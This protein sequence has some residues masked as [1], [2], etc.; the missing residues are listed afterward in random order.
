MRIRPLPATLLAATLFG[1][2]SAG[3]QPFPTEAVLEP[4]TSGVTV[5]LHAVSPVDESVVWVSGQ[6]GTWVRTTDG[7]ATWQGGVV[8]GGEALEMRDVHAESATE[9]WLL[10]AGPGDASRIYH[11]TD[12]GATWRLQWTND[13]PAGFYDCME[14]WDAR[15]GAVY[16]DAVNGELRVLRTEDGGATWRLVP[17]SAL[18]RAL[19]GE[20]G[21]AASGTCLT[22]R[23]GGRGWIAA[24][25]AATARVFRT[26][27][28]GATWSAADAPVVAGEA[29]GL[30]SISMVDDRFGTAFGGNLALAD[31][32][33][34][35]VAR[36]ADGG[37]SWSALP[38]LAMLG[39]AYGGVHVPVTD[40]RVL[41][42][43]GPGGADVSFDGAATWRTLDGGSWWGIGTLGTSTTW[44]VGP[45]GAIARVRL[46]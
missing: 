22:T 17:Q 46:R 40:G 36:T 45:E 31:Q 37:R 25:N 20:A 4:Q 18:P 11:T 32:R 6:G 30:T 38:R 16:G 23:P 33:T 1:C 24:G 26:E 44:I 10:S 28:Y 29:A 3:A 15:R 14:F 13:E 2:A 35:N 8:T 42:A 21:F 9:A 5:L 34:D 19:P 41:I 12:A 39:A 7:G 43:V 27:D